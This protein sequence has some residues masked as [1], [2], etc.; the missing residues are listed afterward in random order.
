[1]HSTLAQDKYFQ[2]PGLDFWM[3]V[4]L[5]THESRLQDPNF[6]SENMDIIQIVKN[7]KIQ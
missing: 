1:M 6:A 5:F 4:N 3:G 2:G 7:I